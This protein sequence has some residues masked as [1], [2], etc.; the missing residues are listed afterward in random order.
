MLAAKAI[1]LSQNQEEAACTPIDQ[2]EC[3]I[4]DSNSWF[5][6]KLVSLIARIRHGAR[7]DDRNQS[8]FLLNDPDFI[9]QTFYKYNSTIKF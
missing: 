2:N 5:P 7:W 9:Y 4:N 1:A 3:N 8:I 6:W